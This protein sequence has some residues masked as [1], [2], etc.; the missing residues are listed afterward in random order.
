MK[1]LLLLFP[2]LFFQSCRSQPVEN[3]KTNADDN[4]LLWEISG[5]GLT[6]PSYLFGTFHL[7]C[8]EDIHLSG[9]LKE[10]VKNAKEVYFEMDLDDMANTMGA[11]LYLNM[12]D[13]KKLKD[14][15]TADEYARV[16]AFFRDSL[17]SSLTMMERMKPNFLQALLYPKMMPCK[18]MS[19]IE[20]AI[21]AIAKQDKKE[22][23]GFETIKFQASVFDSVPYQEQAKDL[24]NMI[25]SIPAYSKY[26]D[27]MLTVYK[28]QQLSALEKMFSDPRFNMDEKNQ[29]I[30]LD[31]RNRN[32]VE[33]LK[34]ILPKKNIF[35]AVG[36]GHLVGDKGLISLLRKEGYTVRPLVN[37]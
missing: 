17:R 7:M 35:I 4:S 10:A 21:M 31:N 37:K 20:E 24:L 13:G 28:T 1:Y 3:F 5:N 30:L 26:F 18:T 2:I 22:I 15:Y 34:A 23:K 6:K 12:N 25:D 29:D 32:W 19:G 33:Q 27:T 16:T 11:L 36:A 14:L 9:N 8:K